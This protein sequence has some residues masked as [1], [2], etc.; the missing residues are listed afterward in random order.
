MNIHINS[1]TETD[2]YEILFNVIY[3]FFFPGLLVDKP[4]VSPYSLCM[5]ININSNTETDP[6]KI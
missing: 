2:A 1:N 3:F 5:N 6:H 4:E